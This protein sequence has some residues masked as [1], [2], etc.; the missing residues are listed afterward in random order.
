[1]NGNARDDRWPAAQEPTPT[2]PPVTLAHGLVDRGFPLG[3]S[4]PPEWPPLHVAAETAA[5]V[6][7]PHI[8]PAA[9]QHA[10]APPPAAPP[11]IFPAASQ[12]AAAPSPV[13]PAAA[14]PVFPAAPPPVALTL[15]P[16][17]ARAARGRLALG[18]VLV[19][20]ALMAAAF[21]I[22]TR[23]VV[24]KM[25]PVAAESLRAIK[26]VRRALALAERSARAGAATEALVAPQVFARWQGSPPPRPKIRH[27]GYASLRGGVLFTPDTFN[28]AGSSYD[29][30]LHFHGSTQLVRE[31][32]EVAGLNAAV[33][34]IN[35]GISSGAYEESYA[36]PGVYEALLAD[37]DR[38]LER[39]GLPR[40]R[41]R[42]VA[43]S[44]WSAG[45]GA[46]AKI[47]ELRRGVDPL[48]AVLITDG[49]HCGFMP[50]RPSGLNELQLESFAR[51][52]RLAASGRL[53]FTIT[54]SEIDPVTYASTSA[55]ANYLLEAAAGG[56]V[57]R[58]I[59][60]DAPPH[61]RLRAAEGAVSRRLEKQMIPT[62][63]ASVGDLHVRGFE[64]NTAEHHMA[65]L[66]QMAATVLPELVDRWRY[67]GDPA[68]AVN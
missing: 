40:P 62:T 17:G 2:P 44:A 45:Y 14:P 54:H 36:A 8:F 55:T 59:A 19:L 23:E 35:L 64:G 13:F 24:P 39:R 67:G 43:L 49:I 20:A 56:P 57:E 48:D 46:V 33:A 41:L 16:R 68:P 1:M 38:G 60:L 50:Q 28:P 47:L 53:L 10:A 31:S 66:L 26:P 63:E 52:A 22:V 18:A 51:A 27:E 5:H 6:S 30:L 65:H 37:I 11:H 34:V 12:H 7:P 15:A 61:L 29:L 3:V 58:V 25:P 21:V 32:A 4:P 9:P 42:R